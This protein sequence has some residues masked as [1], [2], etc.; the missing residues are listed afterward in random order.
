MARLRAKLAMEEVGIE[1]LQRQVADLGADL[2]EAQKA[3]PASK[4]PIPVGQYQLRV[5]D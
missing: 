5:G 4:R 2:A 1:K 3:L